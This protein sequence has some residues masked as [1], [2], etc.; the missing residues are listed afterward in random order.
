MS[1]VNEL[2]TGV[3]EYCGQVHTVTVVGDT[4]DVLNRAATEMCTC[5]EAQKAKRKRARDKV[6]SEFLDN[7]FE[8]EE[9]MQFIREAID[10]VELWDG[11]IKAVTVEMDD[12][13]RHTIK[14]NSDFEL[15]ITSKHTVKKDLKP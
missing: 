2:Q 4:P 1:E 8:S 9:D 10:S 13:W 15:I 11:G 6:V 14:L 12:G 7:N 5:A 3:C